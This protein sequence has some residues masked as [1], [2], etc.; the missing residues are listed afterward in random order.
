MARLNDWKIWGTGAG[1]RRR[2]LADAA[3]PLAGLLTCLAIW[4]SLPRLALSIGILWLVAGVAL[5]AIKARHL[6][7]EAVATGFATD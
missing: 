5:G 2:W 6:S 1:A 7:S 4:L 3:V